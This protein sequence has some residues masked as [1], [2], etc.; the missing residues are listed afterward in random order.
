MNP[1]R[2]RPG[3]KLGSLV[4]SVLLLSGFFLLTSVERAHGYIDAGTGSLI[5]QILLGTLFGSLFMLK[6]FWRRVTGQVS[7][8]LPKKKNVEESTK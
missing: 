2:C 4:L 7:R 1:K 3:G 8:I 6:V 5:L